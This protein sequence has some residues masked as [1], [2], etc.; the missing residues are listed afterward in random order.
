ME[1]MTNYWMNRCFELCLLLDDIDT[2]SDTYKDDYE[3]FANYAY[4][5]QQKRW[6]VIGIRDM[7]MLYKMFCKTEMRED[8]LEDKS[9]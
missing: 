7:D 1:E 8:D 5:T 6:K 3:G 2:A 9:G 4:V